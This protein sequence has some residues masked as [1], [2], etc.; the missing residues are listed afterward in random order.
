MVAVRSDIDTHSHYGAMYALE[1]IQNDLNHLHKTSHAQNLRPF[2]QYLNSW[3]PMMT[4]K[5][6]E[7]VRIDSQ[8]CHNIHSHENNDLRIKHL[9]VHVGVYPNCETG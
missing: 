3:L 4:N 1:S 9:C 6:L 8:V 5:L 2:I 7:T